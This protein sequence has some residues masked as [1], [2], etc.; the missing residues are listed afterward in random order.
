[1][2]AKPSSLSKGLFFRAWLLAISETYTNTITLFIKKPLSKWTLNLRKRKKNKKKERE[3]CTPRVTFKIF[4]ISCHQHWPLCDVSADSRGPN[5][6]RSV[7]FGSVGY[8]VVVI[9][10]LLFLLSSATIAFFLHS[11]T[12]YLGQHRYVIWRLARPLL[13]IRRS[14][15]ATLTYWFF[16]FA[17]ALHF[18]CK[19]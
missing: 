9:W 14:R 11:S 7:M 15:E 1:M 17:F 18:V 3:I 2:L 19:T 12:S 6:F 4:H 16:F 5:S 10:W 8:R 13:P